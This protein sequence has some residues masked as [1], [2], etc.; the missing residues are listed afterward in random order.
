MFGDSFRMGITTE[1]SG[2]IISKS[3]LY[4][5]LAGTF[6]SRLGPALPQV[7]RSGPGDDQYGKHHSHRPAIAVD[8][9]ERLL[10]VHDGED[11]LAE[12]SDASPNGNGP[13]ERRQ[14]NV[15]DAAHEHE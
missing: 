12:I 3:L 2:L 15:R 4:R 5:Y 14:W 7:I 9:I 11:A 6:G 13:D 8:V 10:S 1:S